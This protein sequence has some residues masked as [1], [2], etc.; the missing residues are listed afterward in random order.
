MHPEGRLADAAVAETLA[1]HATPDE[2]A[3]RLHC[4]ASAGRSCARA[5]KSSSSPPP[6]SARC[7]PP[8][9]CPTAP[10]E[11]G[12]S[13]DALRATYTR[14]RTIRRRYTVLDLAHEAGVLEAC[15]DEVLAPG[16]FPT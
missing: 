2:R 10:E 12:L 4:C 16:G 13:R 1:K 11:I 14:A 8:P 6:R 15:A 9:G 3:A 7:S 5:S